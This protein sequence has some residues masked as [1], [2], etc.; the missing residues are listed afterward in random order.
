MGHT[1]RAYPV[2]IVLI[3]SDRLISAATDREESNTDRWSSTLI[4]GWSCH[5]YTPPCNCTCN[6]AR[7]RC[8]PGS[9]LRTTI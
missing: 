2:V 8:L 6:A 3:G 4:P 7:R 1:T 5:A 9:P